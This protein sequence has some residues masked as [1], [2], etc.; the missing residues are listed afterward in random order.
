[1]NRD[2][3]TTNPGIL[4]SDEFKKDGTLKCKFNGFEATLISVFSDV[5]CTGDFE[6]SKVGIVLVYNNQSEENRILWDILFNKHTTRIFVIPE[7]TDGVLCHL[8]D[9]KNALINNQWRYYQM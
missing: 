9:L 6:L 5:V 2:E 8:A 3:I 7:N 4:L 1:M